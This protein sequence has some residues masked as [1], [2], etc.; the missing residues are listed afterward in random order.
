[1]V[2]SHNCFHA[3]EDVPVGLNMS[4]DNLGLAYGMFT[5]CFAVSYLDPDNVNKLQLTCI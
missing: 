1:M 2:G 4:L 3:P 5:L